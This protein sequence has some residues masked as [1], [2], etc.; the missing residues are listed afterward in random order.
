[1]Q[2]ARP[3]PPARRVHVPVALQGGSAAPIES[4]RSVAPDRCRRLRSS[5]ASYRSSSKGTTGAGIDPGPQQS[6]RRA[7]T[8]RAA[9]APAARPGSF[10]PSLRTL[11]NRGRGASLRQA[12]RQMSLEMPSA[13][14]LTSSYDDHTSPQ[15]HHMSPPPE[16]TCRP[17][18]PLERKAALLIDV[19]RF[20]NGL[21]RMPGVL[22][23]VE[24][25]RQ[26]PSMDTVNGMAPCGTNSGEWDALNLPLSDTRS[27]PQAGTREWQVWSHPLSR[28]P[29]N[30]AP[31][32]S[33]EG[34]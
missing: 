3:W 19:V 33:P 32:R 5:R 4:S 22:T 14:V 10:P 13:K 31:R 16:D 26:K 18:S 24:V 6:A 12:P 17:S 7:A 27:R 8:R 28:R 11:G 20:S 15:A 34:G 1:M 9:L 23:V 29:T 30:C 25:N 2:R 21:T